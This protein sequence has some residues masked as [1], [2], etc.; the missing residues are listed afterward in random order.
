MS[1]KTKTEKEVVR[2]IRLDELIKD[3]KQGGKGNGKHIHRA[4]IPNEGEPER[5]NPIKV[6]LDND[7]ESIF[8]DRPLEDFE[9]RMIF[10][11]RELNERTNGLMRFL[12]NEESPKKTSALMW[13]SL[14]EQYKAMKTYR[15]CL[16]ERLVMLKLEK[17]I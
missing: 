7:G 4:F 1:K 12:N 6:R 10:E 9:V 11:F 15:S 14:H 8:A 13:Q 2:L 17:Y 16:Y 5:K 3:F